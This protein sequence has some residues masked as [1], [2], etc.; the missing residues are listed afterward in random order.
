MELTLAVNQA[1]GLTQVNYIVHSGAPYFALQRGQCPI[2]DLSWPIQ[3]AMLADE[4]S[5]EQ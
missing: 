1:N 4:V 5:T 2:G 3:T